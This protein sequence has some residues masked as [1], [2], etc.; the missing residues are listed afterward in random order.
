MRKSESDPLFIVQA[1]KKLQFGFYR[2]LHDQAWKDRHISMCSI[3][4]TLLKLWAR[5]Q[6]KIPPF[7]SV[8]SKVLRVG[9]IFLVSFET[10]PKGQVFQKQ[11]SISCLRGFE[12]PD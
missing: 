11:L 7:M 1:G 5:E 4:G 12:H 2:L 3:L 8:I 6:G 10:L 9:Q